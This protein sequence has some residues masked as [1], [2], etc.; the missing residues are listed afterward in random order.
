MADFSVN[1][2]SETHCKFW[3]SAR[4]IALVM[5]GTHKYRNIAHSKRLDPYNQNFYKIVTTASY[6]HSLEALP[7]QNVWSSTNHLKWNFHR[8]FKNCKNN[9]LKNLP[10]KNLLHLISWICLLYIVKDYSHL[11]CFRT[12]NGCSLSILFSVTFTPKNQLH[13]QFCQKYYEHWNIYRV[14][15]MT[16]IFLHFS[17]KIQNHRS[18]LKQCFSHWPHQLQIF[19]CLPNLQQ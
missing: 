14:I 12:V 19:P 9:Q 13:P 8:A 7:T 11:A 5:T 6:T 17:Q 4:Y 15:T 16:I 2:P 1:F 3:L 10:H 18:K